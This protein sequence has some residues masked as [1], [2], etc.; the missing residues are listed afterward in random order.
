VHLVLA[1]AV[2]GA[3]AGAAGCNTVARGEHFAKQIEAV[4][5]GKGLTF[6]VHCPER[7]P[8]GHVKDNHFECEIRDPNNGQTAMLAVKLNDEGG[9]A[10]ELSQ[11]GAA[12]LSGPDDATADDPPEAPTPPPSP[13]GD[14]WK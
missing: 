13:G 10:W 12:G 11:P 6:A 14:P 3:V 5:R 4:L 8:L 2:A 7:I 9:M 1:L